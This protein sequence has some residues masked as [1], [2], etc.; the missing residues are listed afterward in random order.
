MKTALFLSAMAL[1]LSSCGGV[2]LVGT[3]AGPVEAI[4]AAEVGYDSYFEKGLDWVAEQLCEDPTRD[5][6]TGDCD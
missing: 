5:P 4:T 6:V 3:A 1:A 2:G